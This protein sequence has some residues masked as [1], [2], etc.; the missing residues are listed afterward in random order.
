MKKMINFVLDCIALQIF[1]NKN[2]VSSMKKRR[3]CDT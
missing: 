3:R 1:F 2:N